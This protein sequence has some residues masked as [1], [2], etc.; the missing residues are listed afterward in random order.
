MK[1]PTTRTAGIF[2]A[3]PGEERAPGENPFG[4]Y[5]LEED[6]C[7]CSDSAEQSGGFSQEFLL[8]FL[9]PGQR[10]VIDQEGAE[11]KQ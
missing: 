10:T 7:I 8:R 9:A 6:I 11:M 4:Y 1:L 5:R 3:E 2:T